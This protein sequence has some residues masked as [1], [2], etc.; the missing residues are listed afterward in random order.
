MW[1]PQKQRNSSL[2]AEFL[3]IQ[4][5]AWQLTS[6]TSLLQVCRLKWYGSVWS[7]ICPTFA[8]LI[9]SCRYSRSSSN[10]KT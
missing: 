5:Q 4:I 1:L 3:V 7:H 2:T 9:L 8:Q 6:L 10:A